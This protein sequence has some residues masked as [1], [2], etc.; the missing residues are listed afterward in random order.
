MVAQDG[1]TMH[2]SRLHNRD[3]HSAMSSME[4]IADISAITEFAVF[5][6]AV[7][8]SLTSAIT[9]NSLIGDM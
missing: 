8:I 6:E 5:S 1:G 7:H 2:K 9:D 3:H 4:E